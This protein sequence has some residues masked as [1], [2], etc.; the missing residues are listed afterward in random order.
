[1]PSVST[2]DLRVPALAL[3]LVL[4]GCAQIAVHSTVAADGTIAEYRIELNTSRTVYGFLEEGVEQQGY[5]SLR[6]Y[7][8][9]NVDEDRVGEV[10][11]DE[12]FEG[13]TVTVSIT[14]EDFEPPANGSITIESTDGMLTYEDT[15]F[16][17]ETAGSIE[18]EQTDAAR[19]MT[20]GIAVDY[21]LTMPGPIVD[22][23]ADVVDGNT[24]EW[25]ESGLDALSD[26]RIYAR[27]EL[28]T[29]A[30]LDGFGVVPAVLAVALLSALAAVR[31]RRSG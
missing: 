24:A 22:S 9:S 29:G 19:T 20:A 5:D 27:S 7:F 21:Y 26:N 11:Y 6:D 30:Q 23:N 28:P 4:A 17:N 18:D 3:L 16:V 2:A 15:V 13:S 31:R 25:H 8:V 10:T 14:V 12:S 1:M